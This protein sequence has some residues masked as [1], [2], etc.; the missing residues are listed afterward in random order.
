MNS[1]FSNLMALLVYI[2]GTD[3]RACINVD[4]WNAEPIGE[5]FISNAE[6]SQPLYVYKTRARLTII[7]IYISYSYTICLLHCVSAAS[8]TKFFATYDDDVS[9]LELRS[10]VTS[11]AAPSTALSQETTQ[12]SLNSA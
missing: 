9:P 2:R 5:S 7:S 4:N 10:R 1:S 12:A 11:R 3:Y 8:I 6:R